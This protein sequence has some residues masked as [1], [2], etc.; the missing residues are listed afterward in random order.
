MVLRAGGCTCSLAGDG[1]EALGRFEAES[2][3]L[4]VTD[5]NMPI[6]DGITFI[7]EVRMRDSTVPILALTTES[8]DP[9]RERGKF[10]G[11]NG[12]VLKPFKPVQFLDIVRQI[13][14]HT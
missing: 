4:I 7:T 10:A 8:E 2:F 11:V 14:G 1:Q 13:V 12:W 5:M 9:I 6:M 3:D